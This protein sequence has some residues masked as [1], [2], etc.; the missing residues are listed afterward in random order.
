M[1]RVAEEGD[2][3]LHTHKKQTLECNST[4]SGTTSI[5]QYL[6]QA[7][8]RFVPFRGKEEDELSD[9][10]L[11]RFERLADG[12]D[13][14]FRLVESG[15]HP[16]RSVHLPSLTRSLLAGDS[17]EF[18]IRTGTGHDRVVLWPWLD[19]SVE[20]GLA[21]LSVKH[22]DQILW[23]KSFHMVIL[24]R[25]S[26]ASNIL[27][28]AMSCLEILPNQF[29]AA[30]AAIR[31]LLTETIIGQSA[32]R[33]SLS[34][35]SI[36]CCRQ[37]QSYHLNHCGPGPPSLYMG[38]DDKHRCSGRTLLP[39]PV[40]WLTASC[41]ASPCIDMKDGL[42]LKLECH[43]SPYLLPEKHS[44]QFELVEHD[45]IRK[46]LPKV[47]DGFYE[48]ETERQALHYKRQIWCPQSSMYCSVTPAF[49]RPLKRSQVYMMECSGNQSMRTAKKKSKS[50]SKSQKFAKT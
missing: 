30:S 31:R 11:R 21:C 47:T 38:D 24:F 13:S 43:V 50:T 18:S 26:E 15:G 20:S 4:T 32:D 3:L 41:Y 34:E 42:P 45:A 37:L 19:Q 40:L 17:V 35:P 44:N 28:T 33:S 22:E 10:T 49:S 27:T 9:N 12:A 8:K 48:D 39:H 14:F 6:I 23:Q 7:A 36:L 16:I 2:D 25:L 29:D 5:S 1:K 46:V